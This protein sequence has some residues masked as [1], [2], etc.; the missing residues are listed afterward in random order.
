MMNSPP[1]TRHDAGG[2]GFFV[3]AP[4]PEWPSS[5]TGTGTGAGTGGPS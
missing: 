5:G 4:V 1:L 3:P 2:G